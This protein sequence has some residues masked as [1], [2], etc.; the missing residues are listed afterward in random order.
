M[1]YY[2][3]Y[4][5]VIEDEEAWNE[6]PVAPA[7]CDLCWAEL[8]ALDHGVGWDKAHLRWLEGVKRL[9]PLEGAFRR[10]RDAKV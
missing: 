7:K 9:S 1:P 6:R 2:C 4:H 5:G 3:K 8:D 10:V